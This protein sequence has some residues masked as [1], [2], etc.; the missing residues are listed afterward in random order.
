VKELAKNI[1]MYPKTFPYDVYELLVSPMFA[2]TAGVNISQNSPFFQRGKVTTF[3]LS[4]E[5][6]PICHHIILIN[7]AENSLK[8][9][10]MKLVSQ[11][12]L[13]WS[14]SHGSL[15]YIFKFSGNINE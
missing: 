2:N 15:F 9:V 5:E 8:V 14:I 13:P 1:W 11:T 10:R 7:R 3:G 12:N 4:R 6:F